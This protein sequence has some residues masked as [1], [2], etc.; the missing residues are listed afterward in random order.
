MVSGGSSYGERLDVHGWFDGHMTATNVELGAHKPICSF[1]TM[2]L[3]RRIPK[4]L[5]TSGASAQVAGLVALI[6]LIAQEVW[7]EPWDPILL[8]AALIQSG[9]PQVD[10]P[11]H[12]GP[13]PDLRRFLRSWA[14]R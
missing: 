6:N 7:G 5:A 10:E 11:T 13:Q 3:C 1:P 9:T 12:I 8:R 2:I 14:N 4:A